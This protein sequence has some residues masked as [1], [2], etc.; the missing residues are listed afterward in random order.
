MDSPKGLVVSRAIGARYLTH[1]TNFR[2]NR[3]RSSSD[4]YKCA[5]GPLLG[6]FALL[7]DRLLSSVVAEFENCMFLEIIIEELITTTIVTVD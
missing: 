7:S 2:A 3:A 1:L 5:L 4:H 6:R